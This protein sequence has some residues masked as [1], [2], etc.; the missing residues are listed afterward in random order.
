MFIDQ[1]TLKNQ[2]H[3]KDPKYYGWEKKIAPKTREQTIKIGHIVSTSFCFSYSNYVLPLVAPYLLPAT[4][5]LMTC[6]V[7][8][9]VG[10]ALN[11]YVEMNPN[12][13]L[14]PWLENGIVQSLFVFL[15]SVAFNF[16]RWFELEYSYEWVERN[17]T[18]SNGTVAM[19]NVSEVTLSVSWVLS[20]SFT[21]LNLPFFLGAPTD[22]MARP[23]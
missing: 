11:R 10:V 13:H 1:V 18:L 3:F 6:S 2:G 8:A 16:S 5:T 14:T 22:K 21:W 9:T 20:R 15:F 4:N 12:F 19:M 7:Y 23:F 17:V